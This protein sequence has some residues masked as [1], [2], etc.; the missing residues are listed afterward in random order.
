M[1]AVQPHIARQLQHG[2]SLATRERLQSVSSTGAIGCFI[3]CAVLGLAEGLTLYV[4]SKFAERY[5]AVTYSLLVRVR[6][7]PAHHMHTRSPVQCAYSR[8]T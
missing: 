6:L 7:L 1:A 4:L 3:L 5:D 8:V 2:F